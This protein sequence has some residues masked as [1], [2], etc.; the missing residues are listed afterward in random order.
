MTVFIEP[1]SPSVFES[2]GIDKALFKEGDPLSNL[3]AD[4]LDT[5]LT[6]C[7]ELFASEDGCVVRSQGFADTIAELKEQTNAIRENTGVMQ[8]QYADYHSDHET[9]IKMMEEGEKRK[10]RRF[11]IMLATASIFIPATVAII[12]KYLP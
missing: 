12:V 9:R 8:A 3:D 6:L 11:T 2:A 4:D 5:I 10:S 1:L 7:R